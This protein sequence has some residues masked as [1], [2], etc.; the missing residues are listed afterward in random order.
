MAHHSEHRVGD[1]KKDISH[2]NGLILIAIC[3]DQLA[4]LYMHIQML[5]PMNRALQTNNIA[6]TQ[7]CT[8][9]G[10]TSRNDVHIQGN[11]TKKTNTLL[12]NSKEK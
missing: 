7:V 8:W 5:G 1:F 4:C 3:I 2:N 6:G 9:K 10:R 12:C 11:K